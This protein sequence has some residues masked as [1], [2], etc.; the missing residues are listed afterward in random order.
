MEDLAKEPFIIRERHSG[1]RRTMEGIL[2][3]KGLPLSRL[4]IVAE[5]G[6]T[7]AVRHAIKARIGIS[8]LSR[9]AVAGDVSQ[10][11]LRALPVKGVS[12]KRPIYLVKRKR[13]ECSP[14]CAAFA[15]FLDEG[16]KASP[17]P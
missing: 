5:M 11:T 3:K 10:G 13:R 8:I 15:Q 16:A 14:L 12:F 6:S 17:S 4:K 9:R 1:T 2:E 7:E